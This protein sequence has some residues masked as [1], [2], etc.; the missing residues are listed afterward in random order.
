MLAFFVRPLRFLVKGMLADDGPRRVAL[1]LAI[2]MI[3][4]LVPKG[5]LVAIALSLLLFGT[6]VNPGA[7]LCAAF[8][9][10]WVA[11]AWEPFLHRAGLLV[12]TAPLMFTLWAPA[13]SAVLANPVAAP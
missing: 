11:I 5:N 2:G 10:S 7:G 9:F 1:G 3:I 13:L 4:G 12:L 6:K 8:V